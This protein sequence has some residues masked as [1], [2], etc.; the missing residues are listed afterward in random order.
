MHRKPIEI[1]ISTVVAIAVI[2]HEAQLSVLDAALKELT[3]N[4]SDYY[5]QECAVIDV[6]NIDCAT[7]DWA[8]LIKLLKQ[9]GFHPVAIRHAPE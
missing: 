1:K 9:A 2:L 6:G 3:A 4:S 8:G 7:L 5:S